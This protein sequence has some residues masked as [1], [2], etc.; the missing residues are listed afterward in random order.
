[1]KR[2]TLFAIAA[3]FTGS[4]FAQNVENENLSD[5]SI[6]IRKGYIGITFGPAFPTG[7]IDNDAISGGAHLNIANFGYLLSEHVGIAATWF[8]TSFYSKYDS[9]TSLGLGGIMVGP[10]LSTASQSRKVEYDLKTMIGFANGTLIE[11]NET[12]S[13]SRALALGIGGA[14]RWNCWKKFSLSC[15]IDY[16]NSKPESINLSSY[17]FVIGVNYRLK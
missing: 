13:S 15:G 10:L 3:L 12:S 4:L 5:Q 14:V 9:K 17:A 2:I 7:D 6:D 8:G 16:Y 11:D 1:M